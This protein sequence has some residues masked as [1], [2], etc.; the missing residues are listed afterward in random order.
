MGLLD[1]EGMDYI[2]SCL[3]PLEFMQTKSLIQ[4]VLESMGVKLEDC[5]NE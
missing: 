1:K 3:N 5:C 2:E 4:G